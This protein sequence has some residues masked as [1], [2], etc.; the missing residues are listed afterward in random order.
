[1]LFA[2]LSETRLVGSVF[3]II[4]PLAFVAAV[5]AVSNQR[6]Q[7]IT[8]LSTC[9]ADCRTQQWDMVAI[10]AQCRWLSIL[11]AVRGIMYVAVPAARPIGLYSAGNRE[12][13]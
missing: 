6:V 2:Y 8:G 11:E 13:Q 4:S 3:R 10:S 1:V 9:R 7:W 12:A 5:H